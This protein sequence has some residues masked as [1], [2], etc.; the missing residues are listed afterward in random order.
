MKRKVKRIERYLLNKVIKKQYKSIDGKLFVRIDEITYNV[1]D[2]S[3]QF[4]VFFGNLTADGSNDFQHSIRLSYVRP[5]ASL[6]YI[7]GAFEQLLI[8]NGF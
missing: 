3:L 5:H 8:I 7:A 1:D 6:N 2:N 4:E